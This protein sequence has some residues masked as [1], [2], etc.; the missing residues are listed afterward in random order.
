FVVGQNI[1]FDI[2]I[3]GAEFYRYAVDSPMASMPILD[4]CTEVTA[5]LLQLPGGRGGRF[6]LPNLTELH[7]Y[8]FGVPFS[9]A[10][11]ATADVEATTRCF[12]ELVRKEVFTTADLQVD[13]GYFVNFREQNPTTIEGVG[14]KHI[15]LKAA[16]KSIL[17][18][19][20]IDTPVVVI[21]EALK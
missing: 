17:Q 15:N 12:F 11:N 18:E 10:H 19:L 16:S 13:Q 1:G 9:E 4:T 8:L 2:N 21:D 14:L 5:N 6:K 7:S 3:M 20:E